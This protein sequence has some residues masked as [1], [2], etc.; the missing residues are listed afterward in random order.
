MRVELYLK[1]ESAEEEAELK[2]WAS[3]HLQTHVQDFL[4]DSLYDQSLNVSLPDMVY[5]GKD[6]EILTE[7]RQGHEDGPILSKMR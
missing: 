5:I 4:E 3:I 6:G 1:A 7:V 2:T